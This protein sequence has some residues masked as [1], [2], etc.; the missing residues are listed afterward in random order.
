MVVNLMVVPMMMM[1]FKAFRQRRLGLIAI[2]AALRDARGKLSCKASVVK[3]VAMPEV[4]SVRLI[5]VETER[6]IDSIGILVQRM[7][8]VIALKEQ[9]SVSI[10]EYCWTFRFVIPTGVG[11]VL[12]IRFV[13]VDII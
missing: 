1:F 6:L 13:L 3:S 4:A 12:M 8:G 9:V 5:P 7:E 11:K 10:R 2:D